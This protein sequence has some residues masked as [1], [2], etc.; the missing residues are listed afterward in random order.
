[1]IEEEIDGLDARIV[2]YFDV[3]AGTSTGGLIVAM[4]TAPA[5]A[6]P[7]RPIYAAKDLAPFYI[8]HSPNIFPRSRRDNIANSLNNL[9]GG[10]KYDGRY[11]NSLT[12]RTLGNITIKQA[13]TGAVIPTFDIKRLQPV[14]FTTYDVRYI[15]KQ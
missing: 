12:K 5:I 7:T 2:D 4:I 3:I 11:L 15:K 14:I 1:M 9:L 13:L 10:P 6:N 8:Q